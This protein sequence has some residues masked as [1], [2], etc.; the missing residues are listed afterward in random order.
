MAISILA[1]VLSGTVSGLG[2][3]GFTLTTRSGI[4]HAITITPTTRSEERERPLMGH[5]RARWLPGCCDRL[6]AKA[7]A[8]RL[9][10]AAAVD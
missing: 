4:S 1:A 6:A 5:D 10:A 8:T 7:A 9:A 2:S 3:S